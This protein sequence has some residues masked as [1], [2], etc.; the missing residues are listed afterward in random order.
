M[1]KFFKFIV[2]TILV[3]FVLINIITAFHAYKFTHFY[4]AGETVIK[5]VEDK[6]GWDK[7]K[8][9]LFGIDAIKQQ[10]IEADS[11]FEKIVLKTKDGIQL[12]GWYIKTGGI[13]KGTVVMFHGHGSKKSSVLHE[14]AGF[15]NF[16][17]NTFLLDFR[18]HGNSGGNTCTIG[19][20]ESEEVK[21]AY[22]FI[23]NKGEKN[24]VLWGIS[25]GA[26]TITKA[27]NDYSLEPSKIILEMPFASIL[28]AASG[29]IKMMGLPGQPLASFITFWGGAE[30]GFWA[31]NMKPAEFAKKITVPAL[32]QWGKNDP[33][34]QQEET[35]AV[36][37]SLAGKK[38][39]VV[40]ETAG[41]ESLCDKEHDK[42]MASVGNFLNQ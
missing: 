40:Y 13:A 8:D 37:E 10:N 39:L 32:L 29:R 31:F 2:R 35:T 1:K 24:I 16:G 27:M 26:A 4:D 9:A 11:A 19:Y 17:Y 36:Y 7:T 38:Q 30:H 22:D 14:S 42:W 34:V 6:T 21:L 3:L 41:H 15:R 23:K 28:Q 18:A 20:N 33:R 25:M 5:K 12:Q